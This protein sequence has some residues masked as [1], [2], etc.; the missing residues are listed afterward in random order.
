MPGSHK[1]TAYDSTSSEDEVSNNYPHTSDHSDNSYNP[2]DSDTSSSSYSSCSSSSDA[3]SYLSNCSEATNDSSQIITNN[4]ITKEDHDF[5]LCIDEDLKVSSDP[6]AS[7]TDSDDTA[8]DSIDTDLENDD[9][10]EKKANEVN[11]T[12][13]K[14]KMLIKVIK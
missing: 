2:S 7:G 9:S 8:S 13:N 10:L 11:L 6:P 4:D 14:V 1:H 5:S 12:D 3:L